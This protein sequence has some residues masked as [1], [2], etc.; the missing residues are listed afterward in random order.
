MAA[1]FAALLRQGA[2]ALSP[3]FVA[4]AMDWAAQGAAI[5]KAGLAGV[6]LRPLAHAIADGLGHPRFRL[7][8]VKPGNTPVSRM[9]GFWGLLT[10]YWLSERWVEAWSLTV[11]IFA[12]TTLLSKSSVWAAMASADFLSAIV[13]FHAPADG[14]DPVTVLMTAVGAFGA[15]HL[16]RIAGIGV[17][18]FLS[19]TLHRKARGWT[20]GRFS[21][22]LLSR[23]H[24]A[25]S[26]MSNRDARPGTAGRMPD[27][28]DQR[29]DECTASLF[30]GM[31]GLAMGVWG[32]VTS[33]Y[34][35]SVAIMSRSVEVAFLERWFAAA[36][37]AA[38]R[39]FGSG[40]G[41][42]LA[43]SPGKYGSALLVG[44]VIAVYVPLG[45]LLAFLLG[46]ILE[47]QT[48]ERQQRD[49]TWRGELNDML[50][51]SS[52][53]A[54][55]SGQRVQARTNSRLYGAIDRVWH[56][57]NI[58]SAGFMVFTDG[59]NFLSRRLVSYLPALPAY[60]SGAMTFR[61]YTATAELAAELIND[62]SWFIQVMPAI[63][64]LKAN[65]LRLNEVA[66]AIDRA[67]DQRVFYGE[68]GVHAFRHLSQDRAL[69]LTLRHVALNHRGHEAEP[70]LTV[71]HI[72]LRAG[73]WAYVRGRNGC[74]KSSLLKAIAGLWPYGSGD[75]VLPQG[76]SLFFAGQDP[77]LPPRLT[78]KELVAY[79]HFGEAFSDVEV[80][81]TLAEVGLG[82][83]IRDMDEV[84]YH[85]KPWNNVFS[86]GQRQRLVLARILVQRPDVLLLDEAC[87][88]LDP[89]AV[90]EFHRLIKERCPDAIVLSIMHEPEPPVS[91]SGK[92]FYDSLVYIENGQ[93]DLV[94]LSVKRAAGHPLAAE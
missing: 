4:M 34:F 24:I 52:Q 15:I 75:I 17:R 55:S 68:T 93:A 30:A 36:A 71:P 39:L 86:G 81:A 85:G 45:T 63:A 12:L 74:G 29:V 90:L 56:R 76:A 92:P 48:L 60:L 18:H 27:N 89:G 6:G 3:G 65:A 11:A 54:I 16:G 50:G 37:D 73:Q 61:T 84:L 10:S 77:D 72:R 13:R 43:F 26:L 57:M 1:A 8:L 59:Y 32:S 79:P 2:L 41:E 62:C 33:I 7:P 21:A 78:L 58:T 69:G 38:G 31:I 67:D 42:A 46:R 28:V 53:L 20:Q 91:P 25:M 94:G 51:R 80:A 9:R 66:D 87:S 19:T 88:A 44:V 23:N 64:T 83:F 35:I 22:A 82:A 49:G 70:F 47:R 40:V 5:A 14:V